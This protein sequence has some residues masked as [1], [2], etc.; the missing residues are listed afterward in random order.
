MLASTMPCTPPSRSAS[1][2]HGVAAELVRRE[3]GAVGGNRHA[4]AGEQGAD[5]RE[6]ARRS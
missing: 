1:R 3:R 5:V 4:A 6:P 2:P